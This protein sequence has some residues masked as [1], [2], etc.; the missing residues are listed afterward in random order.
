MSF[1]LDQLLDA[2]GVSDLSGGRLVKKAAVPTN[3]LSKLAERCRRAVEATPEEALSSNHQELVEKTAAVAI[4]GRILAEINAIDSG[5]VEAIKTA[6]E[7]PQD[8]AKFI[9]AALDAGHSPYE[10][11]QF[12]EKNAGILGRI[13]RRFQSANATRRF[14]KA[15]KL[16]LK[17]D[18]KAHANLREWQDLIRK[19]KHASEGEK[20]ALVSRMRRALGDQSALNAFS[21]MKGHGFDIKDLQKAVPAGAARGGITVAKGTK[22]M[23]AGINIGKTKVGLTSQQ[24]DKMKKPALYAGAGYLGA[25]ALI[26]KNDKPKS[27]RGPVIITG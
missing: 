5:S 27:S 9:K 24:L 21:S 13:G 11:A 18:A 25:R 23:A 2:T 16:G 20:A 14:H 8:Q 1:T 17:A 3:N 12:L 26:G 4:I 19:S 7:P 22:P 10:I 6:S 15:T